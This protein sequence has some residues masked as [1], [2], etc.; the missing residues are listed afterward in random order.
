[1]NNDTRSWPK[2]GYETLEDLHAIFVGPVVED[3]LEIVH[4]CNDWLFREEVAIVKHRVR[5]V[6][7]KSRLNVNLL[8]HERDPILQPRRKSGNPFSYGTRKILDG[9]L[10]IWKALGNTYSD[11]AVCST[12]I[13][14]TFFRVPRVVVQQQTKW[15]LVAGEVQPK[16]TSTDRIVREY[17]KHALVGI[18]SKRKSLQQR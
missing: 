17:V 1:M 4:I 11:V 10:Y 7:P 13:H 6:S 18:V 8:C 5:N 3:G 14:E 2:G 9:T 12:N 16:P 15:L